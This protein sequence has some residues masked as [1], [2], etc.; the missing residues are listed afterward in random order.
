MIKLA[1]LLAALSLAACVS[2][3]DVA[4]L[5][6][7]QEAFWD[8]LQSHCGMAYRGQLASSDSR[9]S[10]FRGRAMIAHWAECSDTRTAIAFHVQAASSS[11]EAVGQTGNWDRT[12]TWIIS[13][14]YIENA[15]QAVPIGLELKHDHRHE[16]GEPDTVTF[17]GGLTQDKG[18][19]RAQDFPVD[20]YSIALFGDNSLG[21]SLTNVWRVEVD[22]VDTVNARFA[23]QLTRRNDPTRLFRVEFDASEPVT[24]PPPAWGW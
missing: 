8:A 23:Y 10:D 2:S 16:D 24:P 6:P 4:S 7:T 20:G 15:A 13:R 5:P 21:A 9:D 14:R 12:R 17:Y 11:S 1:P 3:P 19:P 18:S 22:P